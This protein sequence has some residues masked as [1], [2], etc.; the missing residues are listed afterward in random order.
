MKNK[1]GVQNKYEYS[2]VKLDEVYKRRSSTFS[3]FLAE[4]WWGREKNKL[5][6]KTFLI[7]EMA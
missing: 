6:E 5:V 1:R 4:F 2:Q 3:K 7:V